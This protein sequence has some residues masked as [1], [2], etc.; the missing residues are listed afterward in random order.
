MAF[1]T[2]TPCME[3]RV[4]QLLHDMLLPV[5]TTDMRYKNNSLK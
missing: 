3:V 5:L 4:E 1:F 2:E